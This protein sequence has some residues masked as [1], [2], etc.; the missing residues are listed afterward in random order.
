MIIA[1]PFQILIRSESVPRDPI[2]F[3]RHTTRPFLSLLLLLPRNDG[4]I[5]A[6]TKDG[7]LARDERGIEVPTMMAATATGRQ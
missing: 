4:N 7:K 5:V 2:Y 6:E 1:V 3:T